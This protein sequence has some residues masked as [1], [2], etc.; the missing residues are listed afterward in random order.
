MKSRKTWFW[1]IVTLSPVVVVLSVF[2]GEGWKTPLQLLSPEREG[3]L[4]LRLWR[5]ALGALVG[6]SLSVSGVLL[7]AVLRNPLAE[8]YVLGLSAGAGLGTA[9]CIVSGGLGLAIWMQPAS[10]FAGAMVS[11]LVVY[12]LARVGGRTSP[13]TLILAGVIWGSMCASLLMFMVS[14]STAEGLHA[15]MWWFLGDLQV[16]NVDLVKAVA[17]LS[18]VVFLIISYFARDINALML[19]EESAGHVGLDPERLKLLLLSMAAILTAASVC[20]SGL[21]A[22]VGLTV[23]HAVRSLVGPDHRRLLPAAALGGA[24]FLTVA[25]GIGRT[26]LFPIEVPVGVLTS[27]VGAPFF[28][29]LL[30]GRQKEMWRG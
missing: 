6:S 22:F 26:L 16:T 4:S 10:G 13:H 15:V 5:V 29:L 17:G 20:I 23:P 19:G 18:G 8:P 25:D 14:L 3:I 7:Q 1:Y 24:A 27:L 30:K 28:L 12:L 2:L 11:L 9:L 21:I